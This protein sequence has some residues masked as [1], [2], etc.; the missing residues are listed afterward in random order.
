MAFH[1]RVRNGYLELA[2]RWPERIRILDGMKG[3]DELEA[4]IW[5]SVSRVIGR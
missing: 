3:V 4:I 2:R 5:E 1:E